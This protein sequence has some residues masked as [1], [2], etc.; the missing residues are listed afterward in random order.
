MRT[1]RRVVGRQ[2]AFVAFWSLVLA[3]AILNRADVPRG[4]AFVRA[5]TVPVAV[6]AF[7]VLFDELAF[8]GLASTAIVRAVVAALAVSEV[9][10]FFGGAPLVELA[11][12]AVFISTLA[13][14]RRS[15]GHTSA[16]RMATAVLV[17]LCVNEFIFQ[18][19]GVPARRI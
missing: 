9:A 10:F 13:L 14:K 8:D 12:G 17:A 19:V 6:G 18:Y 15:G 5:A 2:I 4:Q 11:I 3:L 7:V 16:R 1:T